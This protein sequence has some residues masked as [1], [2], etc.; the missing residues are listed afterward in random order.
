MGDVLKPLYLATDNVEI[1]RIAVMEL[2]S[3]AKNLEVRLFVNLR[4]L[5]PVL[6]PPSSFST[7]NKIAAVSP[8][9]CASFPL[10]SG[11]DADVGEL[12][13]DGFNALFLTK[14]HWQKT[15]I[16]VSGVIFK[17][18]MFT[19]KMLEPF[20][21]WVWFMTRFISMTLYIHD[22]WP[23]MRTCNCTKV[24][25]HTGWIL[26]LDADIRLNVKAPLSS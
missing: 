11:W 26:Q 16:W 20:K 12:Q 17:V 19:N 15:D 5:V 21:W 23:S 8:A 22:F 4:I 25:P 2:F 9:N 14:Y 24:N 1:L 7:L 18:F 13:D 10:A 6:D 3:H